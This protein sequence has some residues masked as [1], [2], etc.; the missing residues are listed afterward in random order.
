MLRKAVEKKALS[1][2]ALAQAGPQQAKCR[3]LR[4]ILKKAVQPG[5]NERD[6]EAYILSTLRGRAM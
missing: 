3:V 6:P 2:L 4:R 5:R 1:D